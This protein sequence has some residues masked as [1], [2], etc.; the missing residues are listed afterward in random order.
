MGIHPKS[1]Y[2]KQLENNMGFYRKS[3]DE[4][5][6]IEIKKKADKAKLLK[7]VE[8]SK[9]FSSYKL[10]MI[11]YLRQALICPLIPITSI[12]IDAADLE[13]RSELSNIIKI[14]LK[15]LKTIFI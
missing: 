10:V 8:E 6:L 7:N 13:K 15:K 1:I 11:M 12:I 3:S 14:E 4:E 9:K 5:I 2:K